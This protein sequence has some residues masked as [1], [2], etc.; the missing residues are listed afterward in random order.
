MRKIE[1]TEMIVQKCSIGIFGY[2]CIGNLRDLRL[3]SNILEC[4]KVNYTEMIKIVLELNAN[5]R[6]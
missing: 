2:Q 3:I 1:C 5:D 4:N 6:D